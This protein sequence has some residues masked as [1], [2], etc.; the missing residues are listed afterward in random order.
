MGWEQ[1]WLIQYEKEGCA[2]HIKDNKGL[3]MQTLMTKTII[4][5]KS[6]TMTESELQHLMNMLSLLKKSRYTLSS[7]RI[8]V[9]INTRICRSSGVI[10]CNSF[11]TYGNIPTDSAYRTKM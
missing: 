5:Q 7:A 10:V 6:N 11:S 9:Q 3:E 2:L 1:I 4:S 8:F